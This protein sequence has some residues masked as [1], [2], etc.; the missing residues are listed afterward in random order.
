MTV[1]SKEENSYDLCPSYV[2]EFCLSGGLASRM[3]EGDLDIFFSGENLCCDGTFWY[4]TSNSYSIKRE[5]LMITEQ[6]TS[7]Q[8]TMFPLLCGSGT[9]GLEQ[10]Q[11][12]G[13]GLSNI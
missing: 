10:E 13:N 6:S 2:Q 11:I 3:L 1:H 5:A 9:C 7:A 12:N 8:Q 4:S